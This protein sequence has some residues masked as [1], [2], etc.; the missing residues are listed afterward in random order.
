[1]YYSYVIK[2]LCII[3]NDFGDIFWIYVLIYFEYYLDNNGVS[4]D[5]FKVKICIYVF[6]INLVKCVYFIF[7]EYIIY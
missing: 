1:M 5:C 7:I 3:Y 2:L 6:D 4:Y